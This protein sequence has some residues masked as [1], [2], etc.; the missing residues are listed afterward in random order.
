MLKIDKDGNITITQG[1]SFSIEVAPFTDETHSETY[2]LGEGEYTVLSVRP[3][4][5]AAAILEKRVDVQT[6]QGGLVYDFMPEETA[7]LR[8]EAYV[9]DIAL[10]A[11]DG[12]YRETFIGGGVLKTT[13]KVV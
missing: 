10:Y 11:A 9:Y 1:D 8:R 5:G 7:S 4:P 6:A 2:T 12:T 3:V 13:L